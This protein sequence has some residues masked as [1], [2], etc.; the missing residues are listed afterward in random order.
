VHWGRL[1]FTDQ[2]VCG[3]VLVSLNGKNFPALTAFDLDLKSAV[4]ALTS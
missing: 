2:P 3:Q 4:D 1:V